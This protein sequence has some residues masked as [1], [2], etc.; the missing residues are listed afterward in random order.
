[1]SKQARGGGIVA[2]GTRCANLVG[3][4]EDH[5]ATGA[6][7]TVHTCVNCEREIWLSSISRETAATAGLA[8]LPTCEECVFG[9]RL[10][11]SA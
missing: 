11:A 3:R 6:P 10:G 1:M 2:V 5:L 9:D 8:L 7:W 4:P